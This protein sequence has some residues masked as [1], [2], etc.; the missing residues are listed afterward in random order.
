[1]ERQ[2]P[3]TTIV[4]AVADCLDID[5]ATVAPESRLFDDLGADSLDFIDLLFTLEKRFGVS[6]REGG[7]DAIAR[8]DLSNPAVMCDGFLTLEAVDRL[9]RWLPQLARTADRSCLTPARLY[10]LIT[11]DALAHVIEQRL[12]AESAGA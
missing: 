1:M 12:A 3:L 2:I 6:L 10:S 11:I 8:L 4:E 9:T 7:L 5:P